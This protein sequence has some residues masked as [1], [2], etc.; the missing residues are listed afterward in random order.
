MLSRPT[1]VAE[2]VAND[3]F[4]MCD[5]IEAVFE[6]FEIVWPAASDNHVQ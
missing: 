4:E 6:R 3:G 1:L 5:M 2:S